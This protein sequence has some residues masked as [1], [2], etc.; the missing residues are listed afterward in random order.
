M[1]V[2]SKLAAEIK[3]YDQAKLRLTPRSQPPGST[4]LT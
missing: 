2:T 1:F 3:T 4:I